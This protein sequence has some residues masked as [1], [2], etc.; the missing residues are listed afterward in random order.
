MDK[1]IKTENQLSGILALGLI[2]FFYYIWQIMGLFF[3]V[4]LVICWGYA[5]SRGEGVN[6]IKTFFY[7]MNKKLVYTLTIGI[8]IFL[9]AGLFYWFEW[10]PSEIKKECAEKTKNSIAAFK[11]RDNLYDQCLRENGL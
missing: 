4:L 1:K 11:M 2:V 6:Q 10:R 8:L 9:G 7:F 3:G 5:L